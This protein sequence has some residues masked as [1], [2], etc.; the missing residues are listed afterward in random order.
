VGNHN[1]GVSHD[2]NGWNVGRE[3]TRSVSA[4]IGTWRWRRQ[5]EAAAA[6]TA[7]GDGARRKQWWC[8]E[9]ATRNGARQRRRATAGS[10]EVAT[11]AAAGAQAVRGAET[12]TARGG[13]SDGA[14]G[15]RVV[16]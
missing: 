2:Y 1:C 15:G 8:V 4:R 3:V 6:A 14:W 7:C 10:V 5:V 16:T 12:V 13:D 9:A 11:A